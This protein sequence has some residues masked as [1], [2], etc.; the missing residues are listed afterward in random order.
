MDKK[1]ISLICQGIVIFGA[2]LAFI[3]LF[4]NAAHI[5]LPA[6][7]GGGSRSVDMNGFQF[8]SDTPSA[9]F[10]LTFGLYMTLIVS[11]IT[12]VH[13]ALIIASIKVE[14]L[15]VLSTHRLLKWDMIGLPV[16]LLIVT[17]IYMIGAGNPASGTG[18]SM[19]N[20]MIRPGVGPILALIGG[21]IA[22]A[23]GIAAF[24]TGK[25]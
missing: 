14:A 12:I 11:I 17:A 4:L 23:A 22:V 7:A 13:A 5:S 16:L 15:K 9:S 24:V 25:E 10:W 1:K 21:I 6:I 19:I 2:L 18:A 20:E 3:G 8:A